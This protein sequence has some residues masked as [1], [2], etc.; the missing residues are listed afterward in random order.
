MTKIKRIYAYEIIDS[1][2]YPTI[3]GR[4]LLD[5]GVEVNT[6]VP[7]GTSIGKYEAVELRDKDQQRFKGMG[8]LQPVSY[9]N[10]LI[11]PKLIGISPSKLVDIDLWLIKADETK[12]KSKLGANTTLLI[13]QLVTKAAAKEQGVSL[14]RF[15]NG[16][17][18][19]LFKSEIKLERIPTPI[20]SVING[21]KHANN[22]LDFQEFQIIPTSSFQFSKALQFG[23]DFFHQL[24]KVLE[25]RNASISV[26]VEGGFTPNFAT[27]FDALE[28]IKETIIQMKYQV[29]VDIFLGLDI[30]ATHFYKESSYH[31]KDSAHPL[32][33]TEYYNFI[34]NL[35]KKYAPLVIEDPFDQDDWSNWN[36]LN[37]IVSKETYLVGDDLIASSK[38]RLLRAL[39]EKSCSTLLIKPNQIGTIT[40]TLEV[41][42]I[43]RK[44]NINY[45]ISQRSGETND[46]FI[47]DLAVGV[48]SD[49]VKFGAPSRGERVAKYNRLWEIEREELKK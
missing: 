6:S 43:A 41:I 13:S 20:F 7:A 2:G 40:E 5:T 25:Y 3:E 15:L 1:R 11:G 31:I 37:G 38:D 23:V 17:Y 48:Q 49:F 39:K 26:G 33:Q 9:I 19:Q 24:L 28:V 10:T 27:N 16:V 46:S 14:F 36:K 12:D 34:Q 22:D 45:I 35:L 29:A 18:K 47:A 4:L 30:A 32:N 8:V 44:N 42:D 21:G